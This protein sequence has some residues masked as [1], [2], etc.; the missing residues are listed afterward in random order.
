MTGF[1]LAL[2]AAYVACALLLVLAGRTS[3]VRERRL[4]SG[5]ATL[6]LI[7]GIAKQLQLQDRLTAAARDLLKTAG[8]YDWHEDAQLLL[9]A[10]FAIAFAGIAGLLVSE[11]RGTDRSMKTAATALALLIAFIVVRAASFHAIDEWMMQERLGLRLGW[12]VELAGIAVTAGS[13]LASMSVRK[14]AP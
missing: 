2:A 3:A 9:V 11:L 7:I 4:W 10:I 12:W 14:R 13:A 8:W 5:G 1:R 6:L